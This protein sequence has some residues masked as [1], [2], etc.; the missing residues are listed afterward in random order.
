VKKNIRKLK[1]I[2]CGYYGFGNLGDELILSQ[3]CQIL[4]NTKNKNI[5]LSVLSN[6]PQETAKT[7]NV[8]AFNRHN[9][10]AIFFSIARSN[11]F[12]LGGGGIIQDKTSSASLYYYLVL[13]LLAKMLGKKVVIFSISVNP[14]KKINST[15]CAWVLNMFNGVM[16]R[17]EFSYNYLKKIGV[18]VNNLTLGIDPVFAHRI[19]KNIN[20]KSRVLFILRQQK[21]INGLERVVANFADF[22]SKKSLERVIFGYFQKTDFKFCENVIAL[23]PNIVEHINPVEFSFENLSIFSN[24]NFVLTQRYHGAVLAIKAK[25]P[26]I[27]L[28]DD[29]KL[30]EIAREFSQFVVSPS[31]LDCNE[32][33][34][35]AFDELWQN[36][37][38]YSQNIEQVS[39]KL[40]AK[41]R[42]STEF[43]YRCVN[44]I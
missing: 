12:L 41:I 11:V 30:I 36:Y 15:I 8:K 40:D 18:R 13:C 26:F 5:D 32:R 9:P 43:L 23:L 35:K 6:S 24:V 29:E 20:E 42:Q 19:V 14:L 37:E 4:L 3:L 38:T 34:I 31:A 16:L 10:I 44:L 28:S 22:V 27:A 21:G 7:H 1:I 17:D 39:T 25:I 2:I 33:L